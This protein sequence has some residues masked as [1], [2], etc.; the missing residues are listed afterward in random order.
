VGDGERFDWVQV[1]IRQNGPGNEAAAAYGESDEGETFT[2]T[3]EVDT[4]M[5]EPSEPFMPGR[6]AEGVAM[7]RVIYPNDETRVEWW[8]DPVVIDPPEKGTA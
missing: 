4:E 3:W 8:T 7:A 5:T 6:P 1:W 2:G